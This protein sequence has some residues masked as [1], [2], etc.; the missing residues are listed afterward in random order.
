MVGHDDEFM[1]EKSRS[2]VVVKRIDE[3]MGPSFVSKE[4]AALPSCGGDHVSLAG[5]CRVLSGWSHD[6][7][8][9]AKAALSFLPLTARLKARPFKAHVSRRLADDD[10]ARAEDQDF[11]YVSFGIGCSIIFQF[12]HPS[13]PS[14]V[15]FARDA[16]RSG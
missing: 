9:A 1:E 2:A 16:L 5:V 13:T 10:R 7:T 8:S 12:C 15:R 4:S 3:E 14:I 6:G 11:L